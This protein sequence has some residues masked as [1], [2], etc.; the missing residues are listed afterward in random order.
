MFS[1]EDRLKRAEQHAE[2]VKE[3]KAIQEARHKNDS[4]KKLTT[5]KLVIL[6]LFLILNLILVFSMFAMIYL[7]DLSPL[8]VLI[9]DIGAQVLTAAI[10]MIKATI[11]NRKDGIIFE[12]AM[13]GMEKD[14]AEEDD[15]VG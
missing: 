10:Y 8:P 13:R 4:P 9:T 11:E 12:A 15:S 3:Q 1:Y 6:Y 5:T 2:H 7:Q 14:S